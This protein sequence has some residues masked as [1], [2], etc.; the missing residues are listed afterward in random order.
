MM[1]YGIWRARVVTHNPR[2]SLK[3]ENQLL[4]YKDLRRAVEKIKAQKEMMVKNR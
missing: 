4:I 2:F 3:I 1:R